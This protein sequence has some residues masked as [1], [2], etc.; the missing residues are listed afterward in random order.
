MEQDKT[1][2]EKAKEVQ[3]APDEGA[4]WQN[5]GDGAKDETEPADK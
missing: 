5:E 1:Y 2:E 3:E 4:G